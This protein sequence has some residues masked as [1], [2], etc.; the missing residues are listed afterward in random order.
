MYVGTG[1]VRSYLPYY[2]VRTVYA[3]SST[4]LTRLPF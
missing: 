2:A 1:E 4:V 3:T